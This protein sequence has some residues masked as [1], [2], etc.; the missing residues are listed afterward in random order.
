M[1]AK[2]SVK[3]KALVKKFTAKALV[4]LDKSYQILLETGDKEVIGLADA[5]ADREMEV[6]VSYE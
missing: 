5:P 2:N 4:S 1:K 6:I 3:F